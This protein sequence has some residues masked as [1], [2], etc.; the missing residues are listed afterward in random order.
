MA[1]QKTTW[2]K[3]RGKSDTKLPPLTTDDVQT[4]NTPIPKKQ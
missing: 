1:I 3:S 2:T 4:T